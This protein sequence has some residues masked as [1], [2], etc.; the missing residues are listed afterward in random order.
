MGEVLREIRAEYGI[1]I[2]NGVNEDEM[3]LIFPFKA[4]S[5][6]KTFKNLVKGPQKAPTIGKISE[7]GGIL[8]GM[9]KVEKIDAEL[10]PL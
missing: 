6:W 8:K 4:D 9:K 5:N 1:D 2:I 3:S 10:Y 7:V